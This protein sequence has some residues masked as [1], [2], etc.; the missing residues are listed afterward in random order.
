MHLAMARPWKHPSTGIYWFRKRVPDELRPLVGK[1]EEKQSL[2]TRDPAEA[3]KR[4]AE[5][6]LKV[7][8]RWTNAR[9]GRR[10][11][12]WNEAQ[13]MAGEVY[14]WWLNRFAA[15]PYQQREWSLSIGPTIFETAVPDKRHLDLGFVDP[16][17]GQR[18][19]MEDLCRQAARQLLADRAMAVSEDGEHRLVRAVARALQQASEELEKAKAGTFVG[20]APSFVTHSQPIAHAIPAKPVVSVKFGDLFKGWATEKKPMAKTLYVWERLIKQ[21]E[22]FVGHSNAADITPDDLIRW[23]VAL[24]EEGLSGKTIRDS[25]LAPIRAILQWGVDNRRL[26]ANPAERIT[27]GIKA[28]AGKGRRTFTDDEARTILK[29]AMA[30]TEPHFRWVP[31]LCAYSGARI[32]EVCQLQRQ[33]IHQYEGIWVMKFAAESGHL[34]TAGSE[35]AVPLHPALIEAGFL[36]FVDTVKSGPIF[37]DLTPD[38][39]GRR[40]GNGTKLLSRFVRDLG[41]DDKRLG[42]NHSWRHRMKTL[43][44]R[45]GIEQDIGN[46]ITG[47]G[48]RTVADTYGEFPMEALLRELKKIPTLQLDP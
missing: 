17:L 27:M 41:L 47:H 37:K 28:V 19:H 36:L 21:L 22:E 12:D 42:P 8:E 7:E 39:F 46:A 4:H 5:M 35:R 45:Y 18:S 9:Q 11:L 25:K 24:I 33:D 26:P 29:A 10:D 30:E 13:L 48:R 32:S 16:D 23:K 31:W 20:P 38:R 14:R 1:S 43:A 40:G 6:L 2:G 34:K 3:K 15:D 44:R